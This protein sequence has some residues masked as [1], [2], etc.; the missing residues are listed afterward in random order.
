MLRVADALERSHL[1]EQRKVSF[2]REKNQ[3]VAT[4]HDV[5]DLTFERLALKEKANMFEEVFG[6]PVALQAARATLSEST[7]G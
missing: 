7:H 1:A 6:M 3:F 4:V 2:T 5:Q